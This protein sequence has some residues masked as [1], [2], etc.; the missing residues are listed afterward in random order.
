MPHP[1]PSRRHVFFGGAAL[2]AALVVPRFTL[3]QP[4][5]AGSVPLKAARVERHPL[6][7]SDPLDLFNG[8]LPGPVL[9][10]KRG[11]SLTASVENGLPEPLSVVFPGVRQPQAVISLPELGGAAVA[12]GVSR[13]MSL[14]PP[15]AGTFLYRAFAPDQMRRGLVGALIVEDD[16]PAAFAADHI[17]LIQGFSP[18]PAMPAPVLTVNGEVSPTLESPSGGRARVRLINGSVHFLRLRLREARQ[19]YVLAVDGQPLDPFVLKDGEAQLTPGGR[20][21]LAVDM[22][23]A[24]PVVVEVKTSQQPIQIGILVPVG[25]QSAALDAPPAALSANALPQAIPLEGATRYEVTL[26]TAPVAAS[27]LTLLGRV[28]RD[29]SL[30]LTLVN[31]NDAPVAVQLYGAPARLLDGVDDGWKP[32]WHDAIPVPPKATVRAALAPSVPGKWAIVGQR[33]GDGAIVASR[34]YE[35]K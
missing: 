32:W 11:A 14:S 19:I 35:V 4:V 12:P 27:A 26:G 13:D 30:V 23:H 2:T 15:D 10:V 7:G 31:Q 24:N 5:V 34:A 33:G 25:P 17:L 16:G 8:R 22:G 9:R 28:A 1:R 21:D 18:D 6:G 3:A 29:A 20:L